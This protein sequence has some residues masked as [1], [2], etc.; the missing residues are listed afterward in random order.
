M[1]PS[2]NH[3]I[4]GRITAGE[5]QFGR[6]VSAYTFSNIQSWSLPRDAGFW[7]IGVIQPI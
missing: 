4:A 5:S 1:L 6:E 7:R 3:G 2:R